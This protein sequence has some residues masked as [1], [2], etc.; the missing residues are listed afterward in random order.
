[1]PY[2]ELQTKNEATEEQ[3]YVYS[4]SQPGDLIFKYNLSDFFFQGLKHTLQDINLALPGFIGSSQCFTMVV[5]VEGAKNRQGIL[6]QKLL[7]R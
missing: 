6:R 4:L 3:D 5:V 7:E 2:L 1:M